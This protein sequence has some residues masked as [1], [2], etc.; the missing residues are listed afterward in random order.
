[1][2]QTEAGSDRKLA[3]IACVLLVTLRMSIGWHL[4]YEGWWKI[5]TQSKSQPWSA[6]GYLKNATGPLRPVFREL[7][8]DPSDLNWLNYDLVSAKWDDWK[9]RFLAHYPNV[10]EAGPKGRGT[11]RDQLTRLLEGTEAFVVPLAI[12][13]A[14]VNLAPFKDI[15]TFDEAN[16]QLRVGGQQHLLASERDKLLAMA[17]VDGTDD[18]T[19]TKFRKAVNDLYNASSK[20]SFKERLAVLLKGDP[21]RVGVM[22]TDKSNNV[23]ENRVGEI[24]LYRRQ[25]ERYENRL[26]VAKTDFQFDHLDRQWTELQQLR[27]KLIG[28]VQALEYEMKL[29]AEQL[30][31]AEQLAKGPVPEPWTEIRK[32]NWRTMWGL[33][34]LGFLLIIGL[35]TRLAAVGGAG[36]LTLFYLAAP[37]WPGVPE[38]PGPEHNYVVNKV[39]MEALTLLCFACMPTGKWFGVDALLGGFWSKLRR[40]AA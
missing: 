31:S 17:P 12:L 30:L 11:V 37:P 7:I 21:E 27:R 28:P 13:P 9:D 22:Q 8:G 35:F 38:T 6:E 15:V 4:L 5:D 14:G 23:I 2:P 20:L 24:E 40:K 26:A 19:I 1:M 32:I 10:D 36:L 16:K 3:I 33:T 25:A 39:Y 18:E 34:T 29:A